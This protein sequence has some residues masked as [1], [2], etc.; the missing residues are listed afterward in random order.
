[1]ALLY[2]TITNETEWNAMTASRVL[3]G[4]FRDSE[5]T[6]AA[7]EEEADTAGD[8]IYTESG[9]NVTPTRY[10]ALAHIEA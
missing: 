9:W 4:W 3:T 7:S 1:M 8:D 6:V 5:C 10:P 2:R